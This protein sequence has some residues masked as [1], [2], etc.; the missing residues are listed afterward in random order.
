AVRPG[1]IA[2]GSG[3]AS[4]VVFGT[5]LPR[6]PVVY[7]RDLQDAGQRASSP[8][9]ACMKTAKSSGWRTREPAA[10]RRASD[11]ART[12]SAPAGRSLPDRGATA[13]LRAVGHHRVTVDLIEPRVLLRPRQKRGAEGVAREANDILAPQPEGSSRGQV[14]IADVASEI[15]RVVRV[16]RDA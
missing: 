8:G 7:K 3:S 15:G 13:T 1:S 5:V 10:A 9:R 14:V 4:T 11:R 2:I 6:T 12:R 16:D